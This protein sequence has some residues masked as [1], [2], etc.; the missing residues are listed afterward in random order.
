MRTKYWWIEATVEIF[1]ILTALWYII[2]GEFYALVLWEALAFGYIAVTVAMAW[3]GEITVDIPSH[4]HKSVARWSG[5]FTVVSS[6][7]GV[8]SAVWALV[9]KASKE[10][11][12]IEVGTIASFGVVLSWMLLQTGFAQ[13]YEIIDAQEQRKVF[14]FPGNE[15]DTGPRSL[16]YLYF[17]CNIGTSFSTSDTIV[18]HVK[19]RR[20][21][22]LHSIVS[23]FYN[24]LVVAVAFQ[25]LQSLVA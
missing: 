22:L 2:I 17:S 8:N 3:T 9:A 20:L 7:V 16:N 1:I 14:A 5:V 12:L 21:V 10:E 6:I 13:L 19:G 15:A 18:K 4:D 23:Y 24:A 11:G 25:V